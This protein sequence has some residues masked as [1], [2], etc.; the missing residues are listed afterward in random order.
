MLRP[1]TALA[2]Q[3][4][5]RRLLPFGIVLAG[6]AP[7]P[8]LTRFSEACRHSMLVAPPVFAPGRYERIYPRHGVVFDDRHSAP[9]ADFD[10]LLLPSGAEHARASDLTAGRGA[11]LLHGADPQ[12]AKRIFALFRGHLPDCLLLLSGPASRA[13]APYSSET[14]KLST[15]TGLPIA[16]EKLVL[17]DDPAMLA[18][19]MPGIWGAHFDEPE[20]DA[21]WQALAA[22][23][24]VTA[25]SGESIQAPSAQP[26]IGAIDEDN[27]LI[28]AWSTLENNQPT[29]EAAAETSRAAFA[30]EH[31]QARATVTEML[32]R[33]CAWY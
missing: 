10:V 15:W 22:G 33:V 24:R 11:F 18:A 12:K 20:T 1:T 26:A 5:W 8:N 32:D 4:V 2:M 27:A 13:L 31:R 3:A 17:M 25:K 9:P 23:A 28:A 21:I 7:R 14:V 6:V 30:A 29:R 16:P 19:I